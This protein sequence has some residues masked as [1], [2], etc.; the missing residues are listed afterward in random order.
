MLLAIGPLRFCEFTRKATRFSPQ[1]HNNSSPTRMSISIATF[2]YVGVEIVAA[3]A[4]EA[5]W[6]RRDEKD[7]TAR[8]TSDISLIG[9]TV[10]FTAV[11][12]SVLATFAYSVTGVLATFDIPRYDCQLPRLSWVNSTDIQCYEPP[13]SNTTSAFV[14]IA[15]ESGIPHLADIFNVFLVFT[16]LSCANTNLYVASRALF[17]LT[18]R[19]DGGSGQSW[20][21]RL[22]SWFGKT[23]RH[24]VPMRA[25]I[26]SAVAFWWVPFLQLRGGTD[27]RTT[28]GMVSLL[29]C[30]LLLVDG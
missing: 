6:P 10:K 7:E 16:G 4:L 20:F 24:K 27:T 13:T 21:L 8:K 1:A 2:A 23:N 5:R 30:V 18:S 25:M 9:N 17:G 19:L 15:V 3:S 29:Q 22:L 26:F 28:I 11:F 12:I 14:A